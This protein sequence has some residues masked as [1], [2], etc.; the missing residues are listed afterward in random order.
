MTEKSPGQAACEAFWEYMNTGPDGQP[1]SAAW[2]WAKSQGAQGAWMA[3]SMAAVEAFEMA[4]RSQPARVHDDEG[5]T[6][7]ADSSPAAPLDDW[8][9]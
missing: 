2:D 4:R 3:A 7:P 8:G 6:F 9:W 1:P 5:V